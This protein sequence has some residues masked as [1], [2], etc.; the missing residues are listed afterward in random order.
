MRKLFTIAVAMAM[1]V[2]VTGEWALA[3]APTAAVKK[4]SKGGSVLTAQLVPATGGIATSVASAKLQ[5][6]G[7][8]NGGN[9]FAAQTTVPSVKL[10][11][12]GLAGSGVPIAETGSLE[13]ELIVNGAPVSVATFPVPV[14]AGNASVTGALP[15]NAGDS[16]EIAGFRI[17]DSQSKDL[18]RPGLTA[19]ATSTT[20][21]V[22]GTISNLAGT[23]PD[24]TFTVGGLTVTTDMNTVYEDGTCATLAND[25]SVEVKGVVQPNNG[26]N[27]ATKVEFSDD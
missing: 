26:P 4:G 22:E 18:L 25:V 6:G 16:V 13:I 2:A 23:C 11:I 9:D 14:V 15:V 21:K 10:T 12:Q 5:I 3:G 17:L 1:L 7:G 27:L 19:Q 24:T 8:G 20:F